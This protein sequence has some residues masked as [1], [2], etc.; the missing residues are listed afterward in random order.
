MSWATCARSGAAV[1][2]RAGI[3]REAFW[4]L[5]QMQRDLDA[6][7]ARTG[8]HHTHRQQYERSRGVVTRWRIR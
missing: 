5:A 8:T 6:I 2:Y 3:D 4:P 1:L 7:A